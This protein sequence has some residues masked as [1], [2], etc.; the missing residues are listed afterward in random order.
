MDGEVV[1]FKARAVVQGHRQVKGINFEETFAPTP[2]F[3]SLRCL[4]EVA[5]AYQWETATFDVKTAYLISPLEEEVFIRPLAGKIL[6][7]A[8]NV[9]R[10][11]KSMYGLKQAAQCWWNHLRAILTT[12]GFQMN[13]G[14]QSTYFY[15]QGEDVA[16]LWVHVDDGILMASNQHL[17]MKLWEALS[18]AVQLKWDLM[19]HSIVGIEVQQVGRGFQLSQRALIAKLLADHTNNFSPRQT[20]PNMV[21]KSEA[22]RSVDRG[23]LSKIGMI[24]YLAQAT[25]PDVTFAMNYLARFSMAANAHHWHALKHLISYLENTIEESLTIEA[26]IDK[27]IAKMYID[28]NWG[29]EGSRSQQ[30]YICKVWI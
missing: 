2:T 21:L 6:R 3:Q 1:W 20:L 28:A 27:K 19:L 10:L 4:L 18:T 14:D 7:V 13:D 22:A 15:K 8:G 26:N 24:L 17:M 30:G 25:R 12:V 9:L 23:Y 5:S 16:M 29:G 11:K